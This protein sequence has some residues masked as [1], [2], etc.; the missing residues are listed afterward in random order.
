MGYLGGY[1]V[2]LDFDGEKKTLQVEVKHTQRMDIYRCNYTRSDDIGSLTDHNVDNPGDLFHLLQQALCP[3][4]SGTLIFEEKANALVYTCKPFNKVLN[5]KFSL[6]KV[7]SSE[8][9]K[10]NYLFTKL[11]DV[12]LLTISP[13]FRPGGNFRFSNNNRQA[14]KIP[15]R[16]ALQAQPAYGVAATPPY[17]GRCASPCFF[18]KGRQKYSVKILHSA[19]PGNFYVGVALK[20]VERTQGNYRAEKAW[21]LCLLDGNMYSGGK[22]L[23]YAGKHY[24]MNQSSYCGNRYA[25][26]MQWQYQNVPTQPYLDLRRLPVRD[27]DVMSL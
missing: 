13:R 10:F 21:M 15:Q 20:S 1:E 14:T 17:E 16:G 8:Q 2:R 24:D 22:I 9:E 26:Q 18:P 3:N 4:P 12:S 25:Q 7:V 19:I 5:W 23:S 27:G 6:N 11:S